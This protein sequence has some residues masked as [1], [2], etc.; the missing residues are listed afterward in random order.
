MKKTQK[1]FILIILLIQF[2][3]I[4]VFANTKNIVKTKSNIETTE[5]IALELDCE[6]AILLEEKSGIIVYEKNSNEKLYPASTTKILTAILVLENCKLSDSITV[7]ENSINDIP[8]GYVIGDLRV[9]EKFTIEDMLYTLMLKSANDVAVL[10][11]EHVSGSVENFS[12]LMNRKAIEI[13]CKN[14]HFVNPN[15]IHNDDHYT[16]AYDLALIAKYCMQNETFK[17]IVSTPEYTLPK[18]NLY[19]YENRT[20]DNTNNLILTKSSYYYENATGIKT[21]YTKEAGSCLISSA[22]KDDINY[23]GVVLNS[24]SNKYGKNTRFTDSKKLFEYG[25]ENFVY[26]EF[27]KQNEVIKKIE[28]ENATKETKDLNLKIEKALIS[29]NNINFDFENL[30]PKIE[31]KENIVAPIVKDEI[32][33]TVTYVVDDIEYTS[34]LLAMNNVEKQFNYWIF[35]I[36]FIILFLGIA[37]LRIKPKKNKR[38][39]VRKRK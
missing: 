7:T 39:N 33:G 6:A 30:E 17:K 12:D 18:T 35:I 3:Q 9:G 10:L 28:I 1:I 32:L 27:K 8:S 25:F 22:T 4:T 36:G 31:L 20:F 34:N 26:N 11:A 23:I 15:G 5:Q 21:G 2:F 24:N 16:T 38:K 37:L 29:F 19:A 14:T 13:G